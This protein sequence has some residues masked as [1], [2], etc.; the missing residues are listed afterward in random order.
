[1][2]RGNRPAYPSAME[3]DG[4]DSHAALTR[5]LRERRQRL[6][7]LDSGFPPRGVRRRQPGLRR[8][9]VAELLGVSAHWYSLFE[10]ATSG[11]RFSR[12]FLT[13][14]MDVFALDQAD[15]ETLQTLAVACGSVQPD[16]SLA[17]DATRLRQIL[18]AVARL[19]RA[20]ARE[21]N[22]TR[23]WTIAIAGLRDTV[24][25]SDTCVKVFMRDG[26]TTR[27]LVKDERSSAQADRNLHPRSSIA[28]PIVADGK[29]HGVIQIDSPE[30]DAFTVVDATIA[31]TIGDQ[32]ATA[33]LPA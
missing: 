27:L 28:V 33:L 16:T 6:R 32:L 17:L 19:S 8:E 25:V 2:R 4:L 21:S 20:L 10:S 15:R 5:F 11:R 26:D 31:A 24:A 7:P 1:M 23:A 30:V 29:M 22:A 18:D 9:E 3:C 14:V 13:R 12:T